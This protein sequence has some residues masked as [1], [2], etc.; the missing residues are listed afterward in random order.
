MKRNNLWNAIQ[1]IYKEKFSIDSN[2]IDYIA[3][4]PILIK[5]LSGYG[6]NRISRS[7]KEDIGYIRSVLLEHL[8]FFGWD[9]D[10]DFNP[11]ALYNRCSGNLNYFR[12]D[13][14]MYSSLDNIRLIDKSFYLC[15]HFYE[16]IEPVIREYYEKN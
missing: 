7:E 3:V 5:C 2:V 6:N 1:L 8:N 14:Q 15:K 10:L 4:R 13:A 11:I 16:I 12:Q 9:R